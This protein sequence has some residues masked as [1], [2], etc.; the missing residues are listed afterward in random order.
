MN[1]IELE[2]PII[3]HRITVSSDRLPA[4]QNCAKVIVLFENTDPQPLRKGALAAL[5]ANPA[6]PVQDGQPLTR[7][8]LYDRTSL[9]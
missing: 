7:E 8:Q 6:Q 5:R 4:Q 2:A 1:A 9:R 3:D